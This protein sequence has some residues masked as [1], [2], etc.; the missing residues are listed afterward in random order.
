MVYI[1]TDVDMSIDSDMAVSFKSPYYG[2]VY[3]KERDLNHGPLFR[4]RLRM[5]PS[6]ADNDS[7]LRGH[8]GGPYIRLH[9]CVPSRVSILGLAIWASTLGPAW[10]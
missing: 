10:L 5:V 6:W 7:G 9:K 1:D 4:R 3:L 8:T 2:H